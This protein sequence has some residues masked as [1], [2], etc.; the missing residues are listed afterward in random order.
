VEGTGDLASLAFRPGG[1][2]GGCFGACFGQVGGHF[3]EAPPDVAEEAHQQQKQHPVGRPAG[4][5]F[6]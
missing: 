5:R 2:I 6:R 1:G 3:Q 4:S